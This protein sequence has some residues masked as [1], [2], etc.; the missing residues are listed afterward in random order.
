MKKT[1]LA[2]LAALT[3]TAA[4]TASAGGQTSGLEHIGC[5]VYMQWWGI[6]RSCVTAHNRWLKVSGAAHCKKSG[7]LGEDYG[8]GIVRFHEAN[9]WFHV[10]AVVSGWT[11]VDIE[12]VHSSDNS[13]AGFLKHIGTVE[14]SNNEPAVITGGADHHGRVGVGAFVTKHDTWSR[15]E[16]LIKN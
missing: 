1:I 12:K 6:P 13:Y 16:A 2:A 7:K 8:A 9:G 10:T 15:V 5:G 4:G 11:V 3:L 14:L